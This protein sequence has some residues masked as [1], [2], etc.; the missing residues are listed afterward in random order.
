MVVLDKFSLRGRDP[1]LEW[2][3]SIDHCNVTIVLWDLFGKR[4][5]TSRVR[6]DGVAFRMRMRL[7]SESATPQRIAAQ[8]SIPGFSSPPL[9][10]PEPPT[11]KVKDDHK[12]NWTV[13]L[14]DADVLRVREVWLDVVRNAGDMHVHGRWWFQPQRWLDLG[15]LT[16]D[17][18]SLDVTYGEA[19][20]GLGLVGKLLVTIDPHN[21]ELLQGTDIFRPVS[22][23]AAL[24]GVSPTPSAVEAWLQVPRMHVAHAGGPF[25]AHLLVDHG[26]VRP[27][28]FV[29]LEP[30]PLEVD[31]AAFHAS[32]SVGAQVH[33]DV[34]NTGNVVTR[35]EAQGRAVVV[36]APPVPPAAV[37]TI[38]VAA[39]AAEIDLVQLGNLD[40]GGSSARLGNVV[41]R[42][43]DVDARAPE[44]TILLPRANNAHGDVDARVEVG[45]DAFQVDDLR[46]VERWVPTGVGIAS[47]EGNVTGALHA[48]LVLPARTVSGGLSIQMSHVAARIRDAT[49]AS[50]V[51]AKLALERGAWEQG[52]WELGPSNVT[53]HD[54]TVLTLRTAR[55]R[56]ALTLR[57]AR[58]RSA[59]TLRTARERSATRTK[60]VAP[61]VVV[62]AVKVSTSMLAMSPQEVKGHVS[63]TV[64]HA[65]IPRVARLASLLP[66]PK[67]M[68]FDGGPVVM[69][70]AA[71]L[72]L[73]AWTVRGHARVDAL[74]LAVQVG[75]R[76]LT[77][78]VAAVIAARN[79][80]GGRQAVDFSGTSIDVRKLTTSQTD[81]ANDGWWGHF[82]LPRA[83]L[84]LR[85]SPTFDAFLTGR[86]R[87]AQPA[88]A[89]LAANTAIPGWLASVF[90]MPNLRLQGGV[91]VT[92]SGFGVHS[93]VAEGGL[94]KIRME[95]QASGGAENAAVLVQFGEV[96]V[97]IELGAGGV[98]VELLNTE[99]WFARAS[100]AI[101]HA[102][103]PRLPNGL[104]RHG[105]VAVSE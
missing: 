26:R 11:P 56:S 58:E 19:A 52:E 54:L 95:Y 18:S 81:S 89:I 59:L 85:P 29:H 55:E 72:D 38:D 69:A 36:D 64:T 71:D 60:G 75:S 97:G 66:L 104:D 102:A 73:P 34:M 105:P 99:A 47:V 2:F 77:G 46:A 16:V 27:G 43:T 39:R 87:D 79:V 92:P 76:T 51:D 35:L 93:F 31:I 62:R 48:S 13:F 86:A 21:Q 49:I 10:D 42:G 32:G 20:I 4:F 63:A 103:V 8:P 101:H 45:V 84:E 9:K 68:G 33:V 61:T 96:R 15:P 83:T 12:G 17:V 53:F 30:A 28:T 37:A 7:D 50:S 22:M 44:I 41:V 3:L 90:S 88:D 65:E 23:D 1:E 40:F 5:H 94:A 80:H 25:V 24:R 57:T 70:G 100:E 6:A 98:G 78:D 82:A 67:D 74:G 91:H 14:E